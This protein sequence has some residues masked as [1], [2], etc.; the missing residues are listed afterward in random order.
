MGTALCNFY[1]VAHLISLCRQ[2][3]FQGCGNNY[4]KKKRGGGQRT[5]ILNSRFLLGVKKVL[6]K[7]VTSK[8]F[9]VWLPSPSLEKGRIF[10][11]V[12]IFIECFTSLFT[13][14]CQQFTLARHSETVVLL[15]LTGKF[16]TV[17]V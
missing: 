1:T 5:A 2:F 17:K 16:G 14:C 13:I 7:I 8:D 3:S 12:F 10:F 9:S 4:L 11:I 6:K 15:N